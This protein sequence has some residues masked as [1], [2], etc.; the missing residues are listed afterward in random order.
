MSLVFPALLTLSTI[1]QAAPGNVNIELDISTSG[2][3]RFGD[4]VPKDKFKECEASKGSQSFH[5]FTAE[6]IEKENNISFS[7]PEYAGKV[8]TPI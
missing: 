5:D 3:C 7:D 6:D 2:V 1:T 8:H 4:K